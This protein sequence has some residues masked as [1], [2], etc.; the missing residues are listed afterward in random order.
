MHRLLQRKNTPRVKSK[1]R[2]LSEIPLTVSSG[3]PK[4]HFNGKSGSKGG[5]KGRCLGCNK[6]GHFAREC[7]NRKDTSH[8]NDHNHSKGIFNDQ[9]YD[10]YNGKVKRNARH[11]GNGRLFKKAR[12]SKYEE[13][14]VVSNKQEEYYL[15]SALFTTS[16]PDSLG[17]WFID[18]GASRH[19][20]GF[21]EALSNLIEKETNLEII[22][23]DDAT[24][25]AKGVGNVTL[26]L[27]QGNSIHLQQVLYV[28]NLKKNLVSISTMENKCYKV[29]FIDGKV[30]VWKRNFKDAFTLGFRVGT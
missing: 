1:Q 12:N 2:R 24:Y 11:H 7:P 13:S 14:N 27:D 8:D 9:T 5:R 17:N 19:F 23:G 28:P 15:R 18:S 30:R 10:R 29:A 6:F 4:G 22:L 21:K 25:P 16:P 3:L 26:Q 20:T